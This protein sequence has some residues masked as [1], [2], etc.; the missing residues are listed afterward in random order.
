MNMTGYQNS[1][2]NYL[3]SDLALATALSLRF[4]VHSINKNNPY[5]VIFVFQKTKELNQFVDLYWKGEIKVNPIEFF[6][7]I[8]VIKT[9]IYQ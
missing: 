1:S 2:C 9:R 8:K 3:T 4:P 7:Q 6:N 5:K